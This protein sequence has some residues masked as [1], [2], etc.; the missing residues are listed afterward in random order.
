MLQGLNSNSALSTFPSPKER[1]LPLS[2][3][4][5]RFFP[6]FHHRTGNAR[7]GQDPVCAGSDRPVSPLYRRALGAPPALLLLLLLVG[8]HREPEGS[9]LELAPRHRPL[10]IHTW[11]I[12]CLGIHTWAITAC[13]NVTV[14]ILPREKSAEEQQATAERSVASII[15][16]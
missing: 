5:Q 4:D 2:V 8:L 7:S 15:P 12:T 11:A 6:S 1:C 13:Q 10:G 9:P 14:V 3:E 16:W